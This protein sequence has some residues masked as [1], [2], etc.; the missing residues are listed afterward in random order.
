M[1]YTVIGL[2]Q[3]GQNLCQELAARNMEVVAVGKTDEAVDDIKDDV[4]LPIVTDYT[5]PNALRELELNSDSS[6]LVTIGDSFEE[7]LLVITHLQ[8]M[9]IKKIYARVMNPVHEHI[10]RQMNIYALINMSR[11]AARQLASQLESADFLRATPI[12]AEHSMVELEIPLFWVGKT[13]AEVDLR[14][15]HKLNLITVRRGSVAGDAQQ[16]RRELLSIPRNPVMD[17]PHPDMAFEEND[18]LILFGREDD[19][20]RFANFSRGGK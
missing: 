14:K 3:F 2:G 20:V 16:S 10:L 13:L 1:K 18:I 4:A 7:N 12:D 5:N 15:E 11:M 9:G 6:V 8:K 19:L 17:T